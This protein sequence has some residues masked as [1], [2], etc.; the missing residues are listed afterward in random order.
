MRQAIVRSSFSLM[1]DFEIS[2]VYGGDTVGSGA[3]CSECRLCLEKEK[4]TPSQRLVK[5]AVCTKCSLDCSHF[6]QK[7][8]EMSG[9]K[10][11]YLTTKMM[12]ETSPR[13][14]FSKKGW[15]IL[16]LPQSLKDLDTGDLVVYSGHVILLI[17][18]V[19][20]GKADFIHATSGQE[21]QNPGMGIQIRRSTYLEGFRGPIMRVLRHKKLIFGQKSEGKILKKITG[22]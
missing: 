15:Q 20:D 17:G 7:V 11:P 16:P 14:L 18:R 9:I 19:Q 21:V 1:E 22:Q 12:L 2:Y 6:V 5:C 3:D 13:E 10:V 8:Y 4:P